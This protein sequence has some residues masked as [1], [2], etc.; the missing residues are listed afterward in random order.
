MFKASALAL[1]LSTAANPLGATTAVDVTI[2]QP[3][4]VII[5]DFT[6][7]KGIKGWFVATP[8]IP[9]FTIALNISK[10]GSAYDPQGLSGLTAFLSGLLD[11]GA[12]DM[13]ASDFKRYLLENNIN[14]SIGQNENNFTISLR[15]TQ[16]KAKEALELVQLILTN[17]RF[18]EDTV[19][20]VRQQMLM[21]LSQSLHSEHTVVHELAVSKLF[22]DHPYNRPIGKMIAELPL[23]NVTD[24]KKFMSTHFCRDQ[25]Q[26]SAAGA[27]DK[28]QL[29]DL[30]DKTLGHLPEKSTAAGINDI[31]PVFDGKVT[32]KNMDIPQSVVMFYQP[33]ISRQDP[34]FY[35]AYVLN[36][37]LGDGNF[38]SRLWNEIREKRG[39]A[40]G[41]GTDIIWN[42]HTFYLTGGTATQN[43][44][45]M[46][47]IKII[48][49]QWQEL[50]DKGVSE[51]ELAFVKQRLI[52]SYPM[53]F[54]STR[55][56]VNI[57]AAYQSDNLGAD[58]I[59][60]RNDLIAAV[61]LDDVNRVAR[62]LLKPDSLTFFIVGKPDGLAQ[63][64]DK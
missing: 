33:G 29:M 2:S 13:K 9:V 56:I 32:V 16:D 63:T 46:D 42:K 31:I 27:I 6:T 51:A 30:L 57:M 54:A 23:I 49:E 26:I 28:Q 52:G 43:K 18:D 15:T 3:S 14:L 58:F 39:L 61:T 62:K 40:Y 45:V 59:N 8:D 48:R 22:K 47:V 11:E 7:A 19:A 37:I 35:A 53:S 17:P 64:V 50:C 21:S 12:G 60:K 25:I 55:Q 44:N 36:K 38:E 4:K 24:L 1:A 20:L 5:N 10:A 41:I 34:D